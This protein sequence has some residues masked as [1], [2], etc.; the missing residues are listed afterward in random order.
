MDN[1]YLSILELQPGATEKDIKAAYRRLSKIYHPDLS[2]DPNAHEKFIQLTEAYNFLTAVGPRPNQERVSYDYNP[3]ADA[4]EYWRRQA[5]AAAFR[6]AKEEAQLQQEMIKK[7]LVSFKFVG[8][9]I[10]TFN[11]LLATDYLLPRK[12]TRQ[13]VLEMEQMIEST[14]RARKGYTNDY[15]VFDDYRM[16]F[17]KNTIIGIQPYQFAYIEA[18]ALFD[19]PMTATL[20]VKGKEKTIKQAYNIYIVFGFIIPVIFLV[21]FLYHFAMRTLDHKLTLALFMAF[22][23]VV[24]LYLLR[25]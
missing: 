12:V 22:L 17:K 10:L 18:T 1:R 9:F 15:I 25:I 11:L 19:K 23:F 7:I 4:Y 20:V 16:K 6:R 3:Q 13:R 21:A 24:Q 5:R 2:K 8:V 14:G